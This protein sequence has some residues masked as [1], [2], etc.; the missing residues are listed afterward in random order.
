VVNDS[1]SIPV[2]ISSSNL[3]DHHGM[4]IG[5][6]LII[7]D[8]SQLMEMELQL[9]RSRRMAA[10][11]KMAAGIAHE[12]RNPLGTLRGFAHYFGSRAGEDKESK[13]YADLMVSEV[14]RLNH[15]I[16]GLLQFA[17]P[18]EPQKK[19]VLLEE[20][21]KKTQT[22]ME[23]DCID[24]SITISVH[25]PPG[26][27][28]VADPDLLLQVLMNLLKNG[29]NASGE[30]GSITVHA[31]ERNGDVAIRVTDNGEGMTEEE[32]E[33]M[34]DPFFTTKKT[35]TGLGLAVSHQII[36]QHR[37]SFEVTSTKNV[38]TEITIVLPS[39]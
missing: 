16:S 13:S 29:I 15:N 9:E 14:D 5:R 33:R 38:G 6:V 28:V 21:L 32:C 36:E 17:R 10:L 20:L 23:G 19:I 25:A 34:F 2:K 22:L 31:Q 11:G 24:S 27:E 18:R 4:R 3:L 37:G 12:I 35:G 8:I 30:G 7:R 26:L 1:G 39:G